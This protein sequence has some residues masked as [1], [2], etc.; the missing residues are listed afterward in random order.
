MAIDR[1]W[2]YAEGSKT[3]EANAAC[4]GNRLFT[5]R[6]RCR[7]QVQF[8]KGTPNYYIIRVC[9]FGSLLSKTADV[10]DI[11]LIV[12][13]QPRF[14]RENWD[15]WRKREKRRLEE[16]R[17]S[18]LRSILPSTELEA[19]HRINRL[20]PYI[21]VVAR[22]RMLEQLTDKG[23]PF[24]VIYA[25]APASSANREVEAAEIDAADA[26]RFLDRLAC[27]PAS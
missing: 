2:R 14:S 11:D 17:P 18:G 27:L 4:K 20:S 1:S 24:Q 10:G 15:E 7:N 13:T 5:S 25:V 26:Q 16:I 3:P 23:E 6:D 8:R 22:E 9:L 21:S 12:I 19:A